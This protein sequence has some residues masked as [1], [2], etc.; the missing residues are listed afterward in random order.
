MPGD[1]EWAALLDAA[2]TTGLAALADADHAARAAAHDAIDAALGRWTGTRHA[3][4]RG[5]GAAGSGIPAAPAF[6]NRDLVLDEHLA[7]RGFIVVV[8]PRRRRRQRYPGSPFHFERTPVTIGATPLLGEDNRDILREL[9]Y[10][11]QI[12]DLRAQGVIAEVPPPV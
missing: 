11:E 3:A 4:R 2:R 7:A 12:D 9:G 10:D 5:Q 8:G 1:A 6:T